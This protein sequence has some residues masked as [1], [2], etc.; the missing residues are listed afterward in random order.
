MTDDYLMKQIESQNR[1]DNPQFGPTKN[2]VRANLHSISKANVDIAEM[3][4]KGIGDNLMTMPA[5]SL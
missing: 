5:I 2:Y 4:A 1:L 3:Q